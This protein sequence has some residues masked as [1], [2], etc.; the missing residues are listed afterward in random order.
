M[1]NQE[2]ILT[3]F[4]TVVYTNKINRE[5]TK[6]ELKELAEYYKAKCKELSHK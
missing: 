1:N 2:N 6:D 3:I 4:P 5:F